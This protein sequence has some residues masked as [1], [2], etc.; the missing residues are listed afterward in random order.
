MKKPS[1]PNDYSFNGDIMFNWIREMTAWGP[2]R[3]G[4][5]AGRNCEDYLVEKLVS[6]GV[7]SV[8][9]EPIEVE[10]CD[11]HTFSLELDDGS[12]FNPIPAQWIPYCAFTASEG[13]TAPLVYADPKKL[14]QG[15]NWKGKIVVTDIGFPALDVQLLNKFSLGIYDPYDT[16]RYVNHPATWV[17]MG[18]H[19]YRMAYKKG[20]VGFI[21]ILKDQP[22]GSYRMYAPYG[23]K[24]KN[25]LDKPLP[26]CWAG[27][28]DGAM[29]RQMAR[30]G[31]AQARMIVN[32]T[33]RKSHTHNVVG[34]IEGK[35][36][37]AIVI[38][39]H[40]DSPFVSPVEDASGCA[41][42]LAVADH[43]AKTRDLNRKLIVLL[44]AGHF[45]GS[46]GTRTFIQ[47]H[48]EDVLPKVA[49]E[50]T[51]EHIAREAVED[52]QGKLT[53]SGLPEGTGIFAPFNNKMVS[54]IL[55]NL[56]K[57]DVHRVFILPPEGPLGDY[58][59]T[60][61][62]DWY[63]AGVPVINMISNPVYLL[64]AEDDYQWVAKDRLP[65]VASFMIDTIRDVDK[66]D[67]NA[68]GEVEF[69][70]MKR[71]MKIIKRIARAKT[72]WFGTRPV[73]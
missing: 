60:D 22:G 50:F 29:L 44:T 20:A 35:T 41:V 13:I 42:V 26:G 43:F 52:Q 12:G 31:K 11:I 38:H 7:L 69:R 30:S 19:F 39:C 8:R 27:R 63:E 10:V 72:T 61:G 58:P 28:D 24:E 9:K 68:I 47:Q 14:I 65:R 40:H 23:F 51:V 4:T 73:Y 33:R 2:R 5:D 3:A 67:R 70:G 18:W 36:D 21:G 32:G 49:L 66:M 59:P 62:G 46:I 53:D 71:K 6:S 45:Y 1:T 16:V 48:R 64:N 54:A 37:E 34:E 15:G 17:R 56:E 57:H 25:I 55:K